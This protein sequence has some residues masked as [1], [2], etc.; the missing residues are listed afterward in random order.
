MDVDQLGLTSR[1]PLT[2][3]VLEVA[4][5]LLLLRI[6]GNYRDFALNAVLGLGVDVFELGPCDP[7]PAYPRPTC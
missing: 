3:A 2:A 6:D 7:D 1:L 5:Q 4:D